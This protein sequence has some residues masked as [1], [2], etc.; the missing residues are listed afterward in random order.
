[1]PPKVGKGK[2]GGKAAVKSGKAGKEADP[3][4]P[5][6]LYARAAAKLNQ[7]KQN[8]VRVAL[9]AT[10]FN[11][12]HQPGFRPPALRGA[13]RIARTTHVLMVMRVA[14]CRWAECIVDVERPLPY[15]STAGMEPPP[16]R[17]RHLEPPNVP[18]RPSWIALT[19][20][21][22]SRSLSLSPRA[23]RQ[24][25]WRFRRTA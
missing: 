12:S 5:E 20:A 18:T 1:M 17:R 8:L 9:L 25:S 3:N 2:G 4:D 13:A 23:C 24:W 10:Q 16:E 6:V 21:S 15:A 19:A 11:Q 7:E 22:R 14:A